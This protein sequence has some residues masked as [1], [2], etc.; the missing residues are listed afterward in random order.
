MNYVA[1]NPDATVTYTASDMCLHVHSDASYLSAPKARS[2]TGGHFF[3]STHPNNT[4]ADVQM[5]NGP[6]HVISKII[7]FVT[8][9]AAE[10]EIGASFIAAQESLPIITCLKQLGHKQPP[11]PIQVDNTTAV[12]FVY[13]TIKQKRSKAIDMR[14]YW[15]QDRCEQGQFRIYWSPGTNNIADYHTKHHPPSHHRKMRPTIFNNENIRILRFNGQPEIQILN[16]L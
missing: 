10:A 11:V 1:S 12:G 16:R 6:I 14:F 15:L 13:K 4:V 5:L 2:R 8:S 3:L 7:K 9:S